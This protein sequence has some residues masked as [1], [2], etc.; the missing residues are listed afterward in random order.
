MV[1]DQ[2]EN[3]SVPD[4]HVIDSLDSSHLVKLGP[5][6][7]MVHSCNISNHR[8][9]LLLSGSTTSSALSK[10]IGG[11]PEKL[12]EIRISA[13]MRKDFKTLKEVE[14]FWLEGEGIIVIERTALESLAAFAGT[15][16][17]EGHFY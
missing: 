15:I 8:Y 16:L 1:K 4:L 9:Y 14:G 5:P 6:P 11:W 2:P 12:K 7:M 17:H 10:L 3:T 13:T